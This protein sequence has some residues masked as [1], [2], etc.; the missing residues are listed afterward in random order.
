MSK[1][2]SLIGQKFGRLTVIDRADNKGNRAMWK[3]VCSCP[4]KNV[5]VVSTQNLKNGHTKSCGCYKLE[6]VLK[7]KTINKTHGMTGTRI[8][9]IWQ[10][11]KARCYN[12]KDKR[13]TDYGDRGITVCDE[14][15]NDFQAFYEWS[16]DNGYKDNLSIDRIDNNNGYTPKN[17]R[18]ST[19]KTQNNNKRSN[20]LLTYNNET[21]TI[22]EWAKIK[23]IKY[24]TLERRLNRLKWSVSK[25][26]NTPVK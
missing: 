16:I 19:V 18:W 15:K 25:A 4:N 14:W 3:C 10:K 20:H 22:S 13:Y 23:K 1:C 24:V 8:F 2:I 7:L 6:T 17:C 26:L 5:C 11:M 21:H 9:T 12:P